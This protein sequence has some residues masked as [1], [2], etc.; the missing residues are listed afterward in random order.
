MPA[1]PAFTVEHAKNG[2]PTL[3]VDGRYVH[4]RH[5]PEREAARAME[6]VVRRE[7]P[8]VVILGAGLG[9][10][11]EYLLAN[12]RLTRLIVFEPEPA[13]EEVAV[14]AGR[15]T[16]DAADSRVVLVRS[17]E[18]LAATL[19]QHAAE[20]F[21]VID[22]PGRTT[23]DP[24]FDR[25]RETLRAFADRLDINRNTLQRFGKLW[26]RN[27]CRNLEHLAAG[28]GVAELADAFRGVPALLLAA[29]P[30]LDQVLPRLRDLADRTLVIAVDTAVAPALRAGVEPDFAVVVDPQYWNARHLDRISAPRTVLISEGSAHPRV[31][32]SFDPPW[33]FCSSVFPLGHAFE[34]VGGRFGSL[35]AGGSVSTTAWDLARWLGSD[36]VY[37]A[38]LD[39]GFPDARTHCRGSYFEELALRLADRLRPAE[40]VVFRYLAGANPAPVPANDG[41]TVLSDRRMA[42]YRTWFASQLQSTHAPPTAVLTRGGADIPG[43]RLATVEEVLALPS[44]RRTIDA[45]IAR[46]RSQASPAPGGGQT[47][48]ALAQVADEL[49]ASLRD[50]SA[51]AGEALAIV[52]GIRADHA[53]GRKPHFSGLEPVDARL[54]GH[55]A[56]AI[57]SFL[58]Q[59]AINRV[60]AGFGSG[61]LEE[62]LAASEELY[63]ALRRGAAYHAD[64]LAAASSRIRGASTR[65]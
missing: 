5:D 17:A 48:C 22:L 43:M 56:A 1:S 61:G 42:V 35:G 36:A 6:P 52:A 19:P 41:G 16:P 34:R 33:Y 27:L 53:A 40:Q 24:Q 38:G 45:G 39:L 21:E 60:R 47:T 18:Q 9:Y 7:P 59:G 15:L 2:S 50:L 14:R 51:L 10:Q 26:V 20:G 55:P 37:A 64:E 30:T 8:A 54:A 29:G 13:L 4:S 32:R 58:A 63:A 23:G 12:T 3:V 65:K 46:I 62:Q 31:F 44:R 57:A 11:A 25:A 49:R 28:R